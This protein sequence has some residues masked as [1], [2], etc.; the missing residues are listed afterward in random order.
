[1]RNQR[2][3]HC[4]L[5]NLLFFFMFWGL[6]LSAS[7][8]L[9]F[10]THGISPPYSAHLFFFAS[11]IYFNSCTPPAAVFCSCRL[12]VSGIRKSLVVYAHRA[13]PRLPS[14]KGLRSKECPRRR[15][16]WR[17]AT[18]GQQETA[19][20]TMSSVQSKMAICHCRVTTDREARNVQGAE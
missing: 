7:R 19:K 6:F 1:M 3:G 9:L 11:R 5:G 10:F 18:A 2:F 15:I 13:R 8:S 17:Y 16:K 12:D 20:Q 4:F 14:C